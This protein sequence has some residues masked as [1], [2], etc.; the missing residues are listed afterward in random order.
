MLVVAVGELATSVYYARKAKDPPDP[1]Y[2]RLAEP[3]YPKPA[4]LR[5][6]AGITKAEAAA[7]N[8]LLT[9]TARMAGLDR[10]FLTSL[11]RAQGAY[12]AR[13]AS[14]DGKQSARAATFARAEAKILDARPALETALRRAIE[15]GG[16]P[17]RLTSAKAKNVQPTRNLRRPPS[18]RCG[19]SGL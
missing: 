11:E 2:K 1:N 10:A 14:W 9:N 12:A 5:A 17:G 18:R 19:R 16:L 3:N 13:D 4:L 8:A 6:S 7:A 15:A